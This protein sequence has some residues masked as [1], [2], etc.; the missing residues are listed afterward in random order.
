MRGCG[1]ASTPPRATPGKTKTTPG[2][3]SKIGVGNGGGSAEQQILAA[4]A[5]E[6]GAAEP[7]AEV[8]MVVREVGGLDQRR[9]RRRREARGAAR[10]NVELVVGE[11]DLVRGR[12]AGDREV[13]E[14]VAV[15]VGALDQAE[16]RRRRHR[17]RRQRRTGGRPRSTR[18]REDAGSV[19]DQQVGDAVAVDVAGGHDA[20]E[21]GPRDGGAAGGRLEARGPAVEDAQPL[22][23]GWAFGQH[24]V[25]EAVA[26]EVGRGADA[27]RGVSAARVEGPDRRGADARRRSCVHPDVLAEIGHDQVAVT[28]AVDVAGALDVEAEAEGLDPGGRQQHGR[29]RRAQTRWPSPRTP[30]RRRRSR[31]RDRRSRHRRRRRRR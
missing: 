31:A 23:G 13:E 19:G 17:R 2:L 26:V 29:G 4:V 28:V 5:V 20:R 1:V 12:A 18:E 7:L 10:I 14:S 9:A 15:E 21:G 16:E 30:A 22:V 8:G 6:V 24:Q 27:D 11:E 25:A 3:L